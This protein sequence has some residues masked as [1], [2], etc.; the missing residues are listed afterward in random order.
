MQKGGVRLFG[1]RPHGLWTQRVS[2]QL[3]A[4]RDVIVHHQQMELLLAL[5]AV[6]GRDQHAAGFDAHHGPRRQVGDGDA[7]LADQRFRLIVGM[8]AA[9]DRAGFARAV[10]QREL[11]QLLGL[12]HRLAG[13]HLH[14]AEI[15]LAEGLEVHELLEQRLDFHLGKVDRL[16]LGLDVVRGGLR[17]LCACVVARSRILDRLHRRDET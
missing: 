10:V 1:H 4:R 15:R 11:E 13:Q 2:V 7:G 6:H 12:G 3:R 8:D 5:L 16:R 9:Q 14:G 17:R